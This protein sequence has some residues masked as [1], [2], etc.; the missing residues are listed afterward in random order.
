MQ[1]RQ[2]KIIYFKEMLDILKDRRTVIS[3]TVIPIL[4]FP[5][6]MFGLGAIVSGQIKKVEEKAKAIAIY[7]A[8]FAPNL[9][10]LIKAESRFKLV[11][12]PHDSLQSAIQDKKLEAAVEFPV[13]FE[14][15]IDAGDTALVIIYYDQAEFR[16]ETAENQLKQIIQEYE[17]KIVEI[18]LVTVNLK[19]DSIHP[20]KIVSRNLAPAEKMGGLVLSLFLPYMLMILCLNGGMYPA[21]DLTAGEKERGTLE[22]LLVSPASRLDIATGKFLA[23]LTASFATGILGMTSIGLS[24]ALGLA[25][26]EE[27]GAAGAFA[28]SPASILLV[29]LLIIPISSLFS[30]LLLALAL[31]ARSYKEAQSYVTPL[32]ILVIFPA[33]ASFVPGFELQTS[34]I[35]IPIMNASLVLKD[36]LLGTFQWGR[37][38]LVFLI[39]TAYAG[40][41]IYVAKRMFEK[42]SVL[43]RI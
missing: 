7:G 28:P 19:K 2:I 39:N 21:M 32:V 24:S 33:F 4:L 13:D 9:A 31:M 15:K 40:L 20:I 38:V 8:E 30:S 1:I 12:V 17:E 36:V 43:F 3:M 25:S 11:E 34:H 42:E 26:F 23:V 29:I 37:I 5:V 22:T 27:Q 10:N 14:A 18:K 6:L 16:S 41:G 35:F